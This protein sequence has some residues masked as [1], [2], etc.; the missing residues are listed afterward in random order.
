MAIVLLLVGESAPGWFP[1]RVVMDVQPGQVTLDVD[2]SQHVF[3]PKAPG[4]WTHVQLAQ[5]DPTQREYQLDGSDVTSRKDRDPNEIR[6]METSPLYQVA[7]WLRDES[8]YSRWD[9]A[10]LT[11]LSD[12]QVVATGRDAVEAAALPAA[13][14][15]EASLRRPEGLSRIDLSTDQPPYHGVLEI[16]RDGR[17]MSWSVGERGSDQVAHWLF[18]D[19]PAPVAAELLQLLGR[20][21]IAGYALLLLAWAL[22]WV[23]S[24]FHRIT[25]APSVDASDSTLESG[26][27]VKAHSGSRR[28]RVGIIAAVSLAWLAVA[29]W[30]TIRLYHQLPHVVDAAAYYFE[31]NIF[32]S[33]RLWFDPPPSV[34]Y[35]KSYFETVMDGRW[36]AQ[37]PPGAPA[38][39]ALGSLA[40]LAW[41]MGPLCGLILIL[42][43]AFAAR[44]LFSPATGWFAL[45]LGVLSPFILF[46]S[47]SFMSHPVAGAAL[48]GAL[49]AF[50]YAERSGRLRWYAVAGALLGWGLL[51][52]E[53]S[54]VVFGAP[55]VVWLLLQRRWQGLGLLLVAGVPFAVGYFA[56]NAQLTGDPL[57]L[58]RNAVNASDVYGFGFTNSADT[59]HTLAAGLV[60]ADEN[61]TLLQF[62]LFGWPPLFALSLV[63]LPFVL[64]KA[65]GYDWLAAGAL[66]LYIAGYLG[67]PGHGI[68][69]GPRYYYEALPWLLLLAARGVQSLII[70]LQDWRLP[71]VAAYSGV[72]GVV[73][74]L[75]LSTVFFYDPHLVE[76]RTDYFAMDNNRGIAIPFM[77][78]TLF[79]PRLTGFDGPTL[80]LVPDEV[81]FKTLAGLNC[82]ALDRERVQDCQVLFFDSGTDHADELMKSYPGRTPLVAKVDN[83]V[84]TLQPYVPKDK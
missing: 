7:A 32:R 44:S 57:L 59:H 47:G 2:G 78:N 46:Q 36:F 27:D 35:L 20:S 49:A 64:G 83:N 38:V 82:A 10:R 74:L 39:Y 80:V 28:A 53:L 15:L 69:L 54:T 33:G 81:V 42:A 58:P 24:R 73:G 40:G 29:S 75:S 19:Q 84:V 18:P 67:V 72:L 63:C 70:T 77:Q 1:V 51:T 16:R 5:P 12:G 3:N 17:S 60:N 4:P 76:R 23:V 45:G 30:V 22:G 8:S 79:G 71:R 6:A 37:Y 25:A 21:A 43:T 62:D 13:F 11:D 50:A 41:L 52:R 66:L 68:V 14:R 55:L 31:T 48:A 9:D 65:R 56:Y 26:P 61:L 34:N